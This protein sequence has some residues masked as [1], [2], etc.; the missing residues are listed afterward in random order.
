MHRVVYPRIFSTD[1]DGLRLLASFDTDGEFATSS[2]RG[3]V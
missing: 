2:S 1:V 3:R